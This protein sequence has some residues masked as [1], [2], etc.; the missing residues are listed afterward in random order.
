M[1]QNKFS[2]FDLGLA[3]VLTTLGYKLIELDQTNPKKVMFAFE[4]EKSIE[5]NIADYWNNKTKLPALTLFNNQKTLKNRIYS[6]A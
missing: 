6:N 1:N 3:T 5:Q 4:S 2:T